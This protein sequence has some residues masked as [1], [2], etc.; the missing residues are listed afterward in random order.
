MVSKL[1]ERINEK[2]EEE[3]LLVIGIRHDEVRE[4]NTVIP[5][6][7]HTDEEGIHIEGE[8]LILDISCGESH[9]VIYD[10]VED[11]FIIQ[12]E[13]VTIYLS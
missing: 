4:L 5:E 3:K 12:G 8:N 9:K 10:E 1:I 7:I 2:I 6:K 13:S 11:Q